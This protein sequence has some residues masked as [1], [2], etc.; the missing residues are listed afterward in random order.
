YKD[1]EEWIS[2][3]LSESPESRIIVPFNSND[4]IKN[5][6]NSYYIR[7]IINKYLYGRDLFDYRLPLKK[8]IYFFGRKDLISNFRDAISKTENRGLFGLRKTGK[9]W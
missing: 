4:L 8:D 3:Y 2:K 1:I 5:K 9:T 7:N 6:D